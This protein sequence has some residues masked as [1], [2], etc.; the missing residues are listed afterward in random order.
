MASQEEYLDQLLKGLNGELN[1]E[2]EIEPEQIGQK[3]VKPNKV[4][5]DA[6]PFQEDSEPDL[7]PDSQVEPTIDIASLLDSLQMDEAELEEETDFP[8]VEDVEQALQRSAK[9][10]QQEQEL[11]TFDADNQDLFELLQQDS[12]EDSQEIHELLHKDANNE[13]ID[14]DIF[15]LLQNIPDVEADV[16]E[17]G[18]MDEAET[19]RVIRAASKSARAAER[20]AQKELKNAQR[21][22]R[23]EQKRQEKLVKKEEKN[24]KNQ[25]K[26]VKEVE[27]VPG[28]ENPLFEVV[29]PEA[30]ALD[31]LF[32]SGD[33]IDAVQMVNELGTVEVQAEDQMAADA[34]FQELTADDSMLDLFAMSD[35]VAVMETED[36]Q[37]QNR[38]QKTSVP[39][40]KQKKS[41][42]NRMLDFLTEEDEEDDSKGN[43]NVSMSSENQN[44]LKEMDAE[45]GKK[46]KKKKGAAG[47]DKKKKKEQKTKKEKKPKKEKAPKPVE[48]PS[49]KLS[50]KKVSVVALL[51]VSACVIIVIIT[52]V[53]AEYTSKREA[54]QAYYDKDYQT[55]YQN[56]FGKDLNESEQVMF[57]RSEMILKIRLWIREYEMFAAEGAE[58]EALDSL[59]Q[60]VHDYPD[61]FEYSSKWDAGADVEAIY[62]ELL[63]ILSEKY[64]LSEADAQKIAD[65]KSDVEYTRAVTAIVEGLSYDQWLEQSKQQGGGS[66]KEDFEKKEPIELLPEEEELGD[67]I[68]F[69][70]NLG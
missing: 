35:D 45:S 68:Q 55:C 46:K 64:H 16:L 49:K 59:I 38:N 43:E 18:T 60:S 56:L 31:A 26:N 22:E 25:K 7:G 65:I 63:G 37:S 9:A 17:D 41:I 5:V 50:K 39:A 27:L 33:E 66:Q 4:F 51:G 58:L 3:D 20:K 15:Q 61:L 10:A 6:M 11:P 52:S 19:E 32:A 8:T 67:D 62:Q 54:R 21:R 23:R 44:I 57:H 70:D 14:E 24:S 2:I 12:G 40:K 36:Q 1:D 13:V 42:F 69:I 28:P 30:V 53:L 48:E 29:E 34:L 47:E